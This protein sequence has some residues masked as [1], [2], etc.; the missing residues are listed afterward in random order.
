LLNLPP[1]ILAALDAGRVLVVPDAGQVAA[2]KLAYAVAQA[3]RGCTRW[4]TPDVLGWHTWI[5]RELAVA[6]TR[7]TRMPR[8]LDETEA[9]LTWRDCAL[10]AA[11]GLEVVAS[12]TLVEA[13]RRAAALAAEWQVSAASLARGPYAEARWLA[14]TL[15]DFEARCRELDAATVSS[16]A[17]RLDHR[18]EATV[19]LAGFAGLTPIQRSIVARWRAAGSEIRSLPSAGLDG[20]VTRAR[21]ADASH[22][23]GAAAD[24]AR[25]RLLAEP[26]SRLLVVVPELDSRRPEVDRAFALALG[27]GT[28]SDPLHCV[29]SP[30][31]LGNAPIVRHL[32]TALHLAL[33]PLDFEAVSTWLRGSHWPHPSPESRARL[34][35][36]LREHLSIRFGWQ[37]LTAALAATPAMLARAATHVRARLHAFET[38]L[39]A[40]ST[41]RPE[42]WSARV[43]A[44]WQALGI[45]DPDGSAERAAYH[46]CL[47][48]LNELATLDRRAG[49]LTFAGTIEWLERF[50]ARSRFDIA[51]ADRAVTVTDALVDPVVRYDGIWVCDLRASTWPRAAQRDPFIP[52]DAQIAAGMPFASAAGQLAEARALLGAWRRATEELVVSWP[53][54]ADDC[55]QLPSAL[56]EEIRDAGTVD[57]PR[58]ASVAS[59]LHAGRMLET[60]DDRDGSRW[61]GGQALPSGARSVDFQIRCAFRAYA[62]LRL[63]SRPLE[64]PGP[65]LD[66]RERGRFVHRVLELTW[67][68]LVDSE[69]LRARRGSALEALVERASAAAAAEMLGEQPRDDRA[70]ALERESRRATRLVLSLCETE[71][72]RAPFT[73]IEREA[74]HAIDCNGVALQVRIDRVD[75]LPDGTLALIDYKTG[76]PKKEDWLGA[77][78]SQPQ[79]LVYLRAMEEGTVAALANAH[80]TAEGA[81]F[82]GVA[83]SAGRLPRV[84]AAGGDAWPRQVRT[85]RRLVEQSVS[86]FVEGRALRDPIEGACETCHLHAFCRIGDAATAELPE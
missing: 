41:A 81:T 24:W 34:D 13:L 42:V 53:A 22:E 79:L 58:A 86:D 35:R 16:I 33:A 19:E 10:D 21:C 83:D 14:C 15:R 72:D 5:G 62:E 25:A 59:V 20:R 7:G 63:A 74:R 71:A 38:A 44:A 39:E 84:A 18:C 56:L 70:R 30:E 78:P 23:L 26:G 29:A 57:A 80:V 73:V 67:R 82:R 31:R 85:W 48:V 66:P 47:D 43:A 46:R 51:R 12:D 50:I 6:R 75:R 76:E 1:Q 32:L 64:R 60:Y 77:R 4:R 9:W 52:A 65:G 17:A 8:A 2:V 54:S 69:G 36:W 49:E 28:E 40:S 37:D 55:E 45:S 11:R 61:E 3:R 27:G 68:E